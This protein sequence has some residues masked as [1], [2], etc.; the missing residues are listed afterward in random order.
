MAKKEKPF[1]ELSHEKFAEVFNKTWEK[2]ETS[3]R[4]EGYLNGLAFSVAV[5]YNHV[6]ELA[7]LDDSDFAS[8]FEYALQKTREMIHERECNQVSG[9]NK[10]I[11]ALTKERDYLKQKI[12][13]F[14]Y[15]LGHLDSVGDTVL[16]LSED[17][18][19][20]TEYERDDEFWLNFDP[21]KKEE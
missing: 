6:S 16:K 5:I 17:A 2:A 20:G 13:E 7:A 15:D 10:K 18:F 19:E 3:G 21:D 9:Y 12:F 1:M 14:Q 11:K 8:D 4:R